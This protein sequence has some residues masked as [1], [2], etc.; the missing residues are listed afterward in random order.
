MTKDYKVYTKNSLDSTRRKA[1][2]TGSR[3]SYLLE[4]SLKESNVALKPLDSK[5]GSSEMANNA[6]TK[7]L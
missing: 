2:S 7:F 6:I 3:I 5:L 4:A 1:I